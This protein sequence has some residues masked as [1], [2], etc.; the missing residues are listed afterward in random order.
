VDDTK[1]DKTGE[2]LIKFR[3]IVF[4]SPFVVL[5]SLIRINRSNMLPVITYGSEKLSHSGNNV[6]GCGCSGR[7]CWGRYLQLRGRR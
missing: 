4:F 6:L 5:R 3:F 7:G 2:M 1:A